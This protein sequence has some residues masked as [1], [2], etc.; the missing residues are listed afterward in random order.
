MARMHCSGKGKSC[1][2]KPFTTTIPTYMPVSIAEVEKMIVH[3]AN[4]GNTAAAI[5]T[6]LR[7]QYGI[8]NVTDVLG[9]N[10]LDFMRKNNCAPVIPDDLTALVEK[11]NNIRKHLTLFKKDNDAKYRLILINSR[12]HRLVRYY[13]GKSVLPSNWK[14]VVNIK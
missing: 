7:D 8:G 2:M 11:A 10:L 13:K 14:P 4:R 12:L 5:G 1:S 9:T 3:M 6:V